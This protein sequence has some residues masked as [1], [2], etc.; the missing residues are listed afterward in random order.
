MTE[1]I[2]KTASDPDWIHQPD[3]DSYYQ[4]AIRPAGNEQPLVVTLDRRYLNTNSQLVQ[5]SQ[6]ILECTTEE[7]AEQFKRW[8]TNDLTTN[9]AMTVGILEQLHDFSYPPPDANQYRMTDNYDDYTNKALLYTDTKT[10]ARDDRY[11]ALSLESNRHDE[12]APLETDNHYQ[13][14][15]VGH[16]DPIDPKHYAEQHERIDKAKM[17]LSRQHEGIAAHAT[18]GPQDPTES[19]QIVI[20]TEEIGGEPVSSVLITARN[21]ENQAQTLNVLPLTEPIDLD[22]AEARAAHFENTLHG[23]HG[24]NGVLKQADLQLST[25]PVPHSQFEEH[26]LP[27]NK[28]EEPGWQRVD[29]DHYLNV[30]EQPNSNELVFTVLSRLREKDGSPIIHQ[31]TLDGLSGLGDLPDAMRQNDSEAWRQANSLYQTRNGT[32]SILNEMLAGYPIDN[33]QPIMRAIDDNG[34]H[35]GIE[36]D[37]QTTELIKYSGARPLLRL[38]LDEHPD[39]EQTGLYEKAL[40]GPDGASGVIDLIDPDQKLNRTRWP[41]EAFESHQPIGEN[42]VIGEDGRWSQAVSY[43]L[44]NG[45]PGHRVDFQETELG[46]EGVPVAVSKAIGH[47]L[48]GNEARRLV[49]HLN[50]ELIE[51][52]GAALQEVE[53][54]SAAERFQNPSN[55]MEL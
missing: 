33:S 7:K 52:P 48:D 9:P 1:P 16:K 34:F 10:S 50:E 44:Q 25:L 39:P 42:W 47:F 5:D 29:V 17:A 3:T 28:P 51:D 37:G 35:Y 38:T 36:S 14:N 24:A 15:F 6:P 11:R 13:K 46:P 21:W 30:E 32:P 27:F 54:R 41:A 26:P 22:A 20:F 12:P 4:A 19:Y 49:D 53:E 55:D 2:N 31:Q 23:P 43:R 40:W 45:Q 8:F 18:D